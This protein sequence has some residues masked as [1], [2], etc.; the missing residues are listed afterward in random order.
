LAL[1]ERIVRELQIQPHDTLSR[2]LAHHIS[3]LILDEKNEN[4]FD[5]S[6]I[7]S[8]IFE[9]IMKLWEHRQSLPGNAYPLKHLD[10][11]LE[12]MKLLDTAW[13][14][15]HQ[16]SQL[17]DSLVSVLDL[18]RSLLMHF[19]VFELSEKTDKVRYEGADSFLDA[20]ELKILE[21]VNKWLK[22]IGVPN[23]IPEIIINAGEGK[24]NTLEIGTEEERSKALLIQK[25]EKTI[26]A[27]N[28][29]KENLT[30]QNR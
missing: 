7:Q 21:I 22:T 18:Q 15:Q 14:S 19:T 9:T 6:G 1:G 5:R 8:Q 13:P 28:S 24:E 20:E 26:T 29:L 11:I 10:S 30:H 27:L 3:E 23:E 16:T 4:D 17:D 25:I 2:W 12:K